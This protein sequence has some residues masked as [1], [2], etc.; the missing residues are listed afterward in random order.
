MWPV[1]GAMG[2]KIRRVVDDMMPK[3][4]TNL[5]PIATQQDAISGGAAVDCEFLD[6]LLQ[7]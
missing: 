1:Q 2:T 3:H 5:A 6:T 4:I 7:G